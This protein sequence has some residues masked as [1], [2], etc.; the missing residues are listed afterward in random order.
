MSAD[1]KEKY[2]FLS[3]KFWQDFILKNYKKPLDK[4]LLSLS[5]KADI[6]SNILAHQLKARQVIETKIPSWKEF[7]N[8]IFPKKINIEQCSSE[9]TAQ[10][11][12]RITKGN[13]CIDLTGGLGVDSFFISQSFKHTTHCEKDQELQ[14]IA[15]K[16]FTTLEA[17]VESRHT[18]GITYLKASDKSYDLIYIDPSRR[19][20]NNNKLVQLNEYTPNILDHLELLMKKGKQ[21]LIK[22]SPLLDI[23]QVI[24]QLTQLKEV[25]CVAVNNECKELLF[26]IDTQT[27][28][29]KT[30]IVCKDLKKEISFTFEYEQEVKSNIKLS[31]PL[32]YLYEPNVSILKAGAFKSIA[33]QFN[34]FKLHTNSHLYTSEKHINSFPGRCFKIISISSLNKKEILPLLEN[35]KANI[36]KRNFPLSVN[37]I[38]KKLGVSDGGNDYLF[39]TTLV[40]DE[41]KILICKKH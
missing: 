2:S 8:L 32:N 10:Y 30:S 13:L 14:F 20:E 40:N 33:L 23:K 3:E 17:K 5:K 19:N 39:A 41:K 38:R 15:D 36:T 12:S 9:L 34:L 29:K 31:K 1:F 35:K 18:D 26:L 27:S 28:H 22:T 25:H 37:D 11:K 16:N 6:D 24:G 7:N 21:I 4:T